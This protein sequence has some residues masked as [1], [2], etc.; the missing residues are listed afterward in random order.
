MYESVSC[1]ME[2]P[3]D[4]VDEWVLCGLFSVLPMIV[5]AFLFGF[6]NVWIHVISRAILIKLGA[7][8]EPEPPPDWPFEKQQKKFSINSK[9]D[10]M[11]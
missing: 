11:I 6:M 10:L 7:L 8:P 1:V 3:C 4:F 2:I 5:F 9:K